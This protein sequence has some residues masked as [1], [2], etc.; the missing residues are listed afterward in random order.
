MIRLVSGGSSLAFYYKGIVNIGKII[1][2]DIVLNLDNIRDFYHRLHIPYAYHDNYEKFL[3][4]LSFEELVVYIIN[5]E[6]LHKILDEEYGYTTTCQLD[7]LELRFFDY[8]F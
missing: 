4:E 3:S 7:I 2:G 5:H 8:W 1:S 6:V